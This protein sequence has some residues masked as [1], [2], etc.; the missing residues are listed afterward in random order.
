MIPILYTNSD[1]VRAAIG[2]KERDYSDKDISNFNLE[3]KLSLDLRAW[4]PSHAAISE[5]AE[6]ATAT[7]GEKDMGAALELYS[8]AFAALDML[9]TLRLGVAQSV[10]D[11]KNQ[12]SRFSSVD[13]AAL[14]TALIANMRQYRRLLEDAV[15]GVSTGPTVPAMFIGVGLATDPVTAVGQ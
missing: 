3:K 15:S 14:E 12:F 13:W 9:Q 10:S 6:Q 1:A 7:D 2:I 8:T 11:G 5:A 4:L